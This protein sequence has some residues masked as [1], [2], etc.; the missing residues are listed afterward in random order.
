LRRQ[1]PIGQS[2]PA[3][4]GYASAGVGSCIEP[5]RLSCPPTITLHRLGRG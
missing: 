5:V 4:A 3:A 1:S 2:S